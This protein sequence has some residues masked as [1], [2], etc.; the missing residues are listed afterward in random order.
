M[1]FIE[2]LEKTAETRQKESIILAVTRRKSEF[3]IAIAET[4]L[5]IANLSS[6]LDEYRCT[7]P[8][9]ELV[10][11]INDI[12]LYQKGLEVLEKEYNTLFPE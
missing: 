12:S 9:S 8:L 11:L 3:S 2:L 10:E 4:K 7:A 5:T 6:K 1:T